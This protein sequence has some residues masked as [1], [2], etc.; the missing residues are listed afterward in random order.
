MQEKVCARA[1]FFSQA[2]LRFGRHHLDQKTFREEHKQQV[3]ERKIAPNPDAGKVCA[4]FL[5]PVRMRERD[6]DKDKQNSQTKLRF[7]EAPLRSKDI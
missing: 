1:Q 5:F 6:E 7:W 4:E 3:E 2:K